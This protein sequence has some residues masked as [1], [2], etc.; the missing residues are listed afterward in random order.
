MKE[1]KSKLGTM[2]FEIIED[3]FKLYDSDQEYIGYVDLASGNFNEEDI[4]LLIED[5][6]QIDHI[7]K[8]VDLGFC[9]NMIFGNSRKE[10]INYL[11]TFQDE[12]FVSAEDY[13]DLD[14]INR[15]R[16]NYFLVDFD[17]YI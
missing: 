9:R 13:E 8:I 14:V 3:R 16:N 15:V 1:I 7:S 6:E 10:V 17:E 2:H 5:L 4:P 12:D 11:L